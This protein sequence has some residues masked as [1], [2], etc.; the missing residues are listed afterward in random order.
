M[1]P[2]VYTHCD[3]ASHQTARVLPHRTLPAA[4]KIH[5]K[6]FRVLSHAS[7]VERELSS[8]F[9]LPPGPTKLKAGQ[10]ARV[11]RMLKMKGR[12]AAKRR[13]MLDGFKL[14]EAC[15]V[16]DPHDAIEAVLTDSGYVGVVKEDLQFFENLEFLD[17]GENTV[18]IADLIGL[19]RIEELHLHCSQLSRVVLP[20]DA[21]PKL[22]T[23]NLSFNA[24]S[25]P[26]IVQT[27]SQLPS[28]LRLDLSGNALAA[29]PPA[30]AMKFP[31]LKQI[32]LENN[33][34][35]GDAV[36]FSLAQIARLQEANLN[37][38]R[39]QRIPYK[40]TGRPNTTRPASARDPD[41]P[42]IDEVD[43]TADAEPVENV[44]FFRALEVIGLANN[45]LMHFEDVTALAGWDRLTR[46]VLW[47]NPL[48]R[49]KQDVDM[50]L[51]D[52]G[53]AN[54]KALFEGPVPPKRSL[55]EFY[56]ANLKN[57]IR[58]GE[59]RKAIPRRQP[60]EQAT[61]APVVVEDESEEEEPQPQAAKGP[62]FFMTEAPVEAAS[63]QQ[64]KPASKSR[65]PGTDS[66]PPARDSVSAASVG[67]GVEDAAK[68]S[69][70]AMDALDGDGAKTSLRPHA[71]NASD[72]GSADAGIPMRDSA[73]D[74]MNE[75]DNLI[76]APTPD[77]L[78]P[79]SNAEGPHPTTLRGAF[80]ELKQVLQN[81]LTAPVNTTLAHRNRGG[82]R[83]RRRA[84]SP[85]TTGRHT[86]GK[87]PPIA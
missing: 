45:Q 29:L 66:R 44:P 47:G 58:V 57:I 80:R 86:H 64:A 51:Y 72:H 31:A 53:R 25:D 54:V 8:Y 46:V 43:G 15:K 40:P 75:L 69:W 65:P 70:F 24:F 41:E 83:A 78:F 42:Y 17:L 21:F 50:L 9:R 5:P 18:D 28:L 73:H 49:R 52:L 7:P 87:L 19:R 33:Q 13:K 32:A 63:P 11:D 48:Q 76:N 10:Q 26:T 37:G 56:T 62:S 79:D 35:S 16:E 3:G 60:A 4:L 1:P 14:L 77:D 82:A 22:E 30:D 36:F 81:P 84:K 20:Q 39:I 55:G 67:Y 71:P 85:S 6:G 74:L 61:A 12:G 23:L 38:N 2:P 27:L 68:L 34:L 59:Y